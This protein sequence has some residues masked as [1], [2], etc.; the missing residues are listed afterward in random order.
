MD[1]NFPAEVEQLRVATSKLVD[2]LLTYEPAFHRT[3]Q[4]PAE[5]DAKFRELG[6]YGLRIPEAFGG[7]ALGMLP[8]I[9]VVSELGRLPPQF[10][11][12][13]RVALGPSSKTLVK[14]G[15]SEQRARWLPAM[16]K[17]Q[18][19]VAFV[20]T[21]AGAGSDLSA[22]RMRAERVDGGYV[23]NGTKTYISNAN[24]ADLF[25][26]FAR[27]STSARLKGGISAFLIEPGQ[28]GMQVGPAM[29]TMGTTLDGL[30]ELSFT[31]CRIPATQLL[32]EEG[33]GFDYAMESLNEGRLN[34]GAI[35][36]GMGRFALKLAIEHVKTRIAFGQ[37]L[38]ANQAVQHK[39]ADAGMELH[40]AWLMLVD[41]AWRVDA[42]A[43]A[44]ATSAMVKVYCAEVAGRA[45]DTAVQLLGAAGYSRGV[46]VERLYRDVR[47]LRIYEGASEILRNAIARKL[48][49]D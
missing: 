24:R 6:Y 21:E 39:L 19:G 15:S 37:P 16:A 23:L 46:P 13:L 32:G 47:V 8:T 40:A 10:W 20:L 45:I 42:G 7:S 17:G 41:T 4:V 35:A 5:V 11:P 2:D 31:D 28:A 25:V 49:S 30:F 22:M 14:H 27:T 48:L 9:A 43:D 12:F 33:K 38:S 18:C 44:S 29:P 3:N 34:V 1:L 36:I 26:L